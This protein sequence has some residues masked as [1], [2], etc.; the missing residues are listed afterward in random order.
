M[1]DFDA[2]YAVAEANRLDVLLF[3]G[4]SL[5]Q[6]MGE[7]CRFF[8]ALDRGATGLGEAG[9][10]DIARVLREIATATGPSRPSKA[11]SAADIRE[12]LGLQDQWTSAAAV[13]GPLATRL[14]ARTARAWTS[15]STGTDA[16]ALDQALAVLRCRACDDYADPARARAALRALGAPTVREALSASIE[17][18][19]LSALC[20][21]RRATAPAAAAQL[22][23]VG[24]M[25]T[26]DAAALLPPVSR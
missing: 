25:A 15:P 2:A 22:S 10:L 7:W 6:A 19:L 26:L 18:L 13:R 12:F 5:E 21:P 1:P 17:G 24:C 8:D 16:D 3:D 20:V 9:A 4:G 11:P 14:R 23:Q